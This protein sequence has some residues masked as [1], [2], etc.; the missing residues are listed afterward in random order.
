ME[1]RA[2]EPLVLAL[3]K[4]GILI[5]SLCRSGECSMCRVKIISG[6]VFQPSG[7]PVRKSDRK[8]GYVHSC[9]SYPLENLEIVI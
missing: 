9:V 7:V 2:G 6:K 8:Y 4:E 1:A 5:P 3:E